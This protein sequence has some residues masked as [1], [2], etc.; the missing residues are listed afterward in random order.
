M[1]NAS[2][3]IFNLFSGIC[4]NKGNDDPVLKRLKEYFPKLASAYL[5]IC[6]TQKREFF[7]LRDFYR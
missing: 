3:P 2:I 5:N 1:R 6:N 7:G 4:S